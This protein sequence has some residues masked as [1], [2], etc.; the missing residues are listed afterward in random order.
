MK[1]LIEAGALGGVNDPNGQLAL[2]TA[3]R[4]YQRS[5]LRCLI[6]E[7]GVSESSEQ[8]SNTRTE[9]EECRG[10]CWSTS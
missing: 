5:A 6:V 10:L 8:V 1:Y 2:A 7:A 3:A 9:I 4:F